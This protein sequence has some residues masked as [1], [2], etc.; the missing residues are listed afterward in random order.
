MINAFSTACSNSYKLNL[1]DMKK[2]SDVELSSLSKK[3]ENE[4]FFSSPCVYLQ[5]LQNVNWTW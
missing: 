3:N 1:I 2:I 5:Y 4:Y